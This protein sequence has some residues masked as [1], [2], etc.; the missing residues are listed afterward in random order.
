MVK[1]EKNF[2][3]K[4]ANCWFWGKKSS[5]SHALIGNWSKFWFLNDK[6]LVLSSKLVKI[7]W[8]PPKSIKI[9]SL[10]G[11]ILNPN[12]KMGQ[13]CS[14]VGISM[15]KIWFKAQNLCQFR[16][17]SQ[18]SEEEE[19]EETFT[20]RIRSCRWTCWRWWR[21]TCR[22]RPCSLWSWQSTWISAWCWT[23]KHPSTTPLWSRPINHNKI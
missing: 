19:E 9:L 5:K 15:T 18:Q 22:R 14:K 21:H 20:R 12:K 6:L 8:I 23:G 10:K 11:Q 3:F 16:C 13:N 1:I 4:S 17:K 7:T 2:D